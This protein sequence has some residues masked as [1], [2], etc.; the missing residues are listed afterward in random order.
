MSQLFNHGAALLCAPDLAHLA[1]HLN[2]T[3]TYLDLTPRLRVDLLKTL[4]ALILE[5]V[6]VR[7]VLARLREHVKECKSKIACTRASGR[8]KGGKKKQDAK[9]EGKQEGSGKQEGDGGKQEGDGG[10]EG[11][12]LVN[13]GEEGQQRDASPEYVLG[14]GCFVH[15][16]HACSTHPCCVF[17][18]SISRSL[19]HIHFALLL[20]TLL[21]HTL[22]SKHRKPII[23]PEEVAR[24]VA[25]LQEEIAAASVREQPI[26]V[27][28]HRRRYWLLGGYVEQTRMHPG[29]LVVEGALRTGA[30]TN[31][32]A[33]TKD[34]AGAA[35]GDN[36]R[37]AAD[38]T[39]HS[40]PH[41]TPRTA[42][43]TSP[44]N[45]DVAMSDAATPLP[46]PTDPTHVPTH[47]QPSS[48]TLADDRT[49]TPHMHWFSSMADVDALLQ[50]L[51]PQGPREGPLRGHVQ[52]YLAALQEAYGGHEGAFSASVQGLLTAAAEKG[53]EE[54]EE[55]DDKD[56]SDDDKEK[57]GE[58]TV[59][60]EAPP[61]PHSPDTT[62]AVPSPH[63]WSPTPPATQFKHDRTAVLTL[64]DTIPG[65][66]YDLAKATPQLLDGLGHAVQSATSY[67]VLLAAVV[68]LEEVLLPGC[69]KPWW[70][71]W[72]LTPG[73][74]PGSLGGMMIHTAG[75]G[76]GE[77]MEKGDTA[78][79]GGGVG[80]PGSVS[81]GPGAL[82]LRLAMLQGALRRP[83]AVEIAG[84]G[85]TARSTRGGGHAGG[86]ARG[87][88]PACHEVCVVCV[89]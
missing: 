35:A 7:S 13:A 74:F 83:P 47:Q 57:Q 12:E 86:A 15:R 45:A 88:R 55:N 1:T 6:E 49:H 81:V 16:E 34:H 87:G 43:V 60:Q 36:A 78:G 32:G 37:V 65:D 29:I 39:G 4:C 56:K 28:R 59:M 79:A 5:T 51:N 84:G 27:D 41:Q 77:H 18:T 19:I 69:F 50:W 38:T 52:A 70:R 73:F 68:V 42:M 89:L 67:E 85:V 54:E 71:P 30:A 20:H 21:L 31:M 46:P 80:A 66:S 40:Q 76:G 75:G 23:P 62:T 72:S 14:G 63:Q 26:G 61:L 9:A 22:L 11:K 48:H 24:I 53:E 44:T 58:D 2:T 82:H 8:P 10:E 64:L 33:A 17:D 25:G 3:H